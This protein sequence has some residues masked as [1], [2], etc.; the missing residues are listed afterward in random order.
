[1][2]W[3]APLCAYVFLCVC[4][5]VREKYTLEQD[6]KETEEA[7]RHKSVEVQVRT[8]ISLVT[9]LQCKHI[10]SFNVDCLNLN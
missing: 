6:I 4:V 1:M 2:C 3:C 9:K 5:C 8:V 10:A 7:I